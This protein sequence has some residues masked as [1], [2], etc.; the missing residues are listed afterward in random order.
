MKKLIVIFVIVGTLIICNNQDIK[1]QEV[2]RGV[3]RKENVPYRVPVP[4]PFMREADV[5]WSKLV[6]RNIDFREKTNHHLYYPTHPIGNRLSLVSLLINHIKPSDN[7]PNPLVVF[8]DEDFKV[9][10]KYDEVLM[11]LGAEEV[12]QEITDIDPITGREFTRTQTVTTEIQ[13]EEVLQLLVKEQW[14]FDRRHSMFRVRILA[15]CP[16]RVYYRLDD[17]GN[18]TDDL[19]RRQLFWVPFEDIRPILVRQEVHSRFNDVSNLSFD[20]VFLQRLFSGFIYQESNVFDN[21]P[22]AEYAIGRAALYE[23]QRIQEFLFNFEQDL[24][25]Y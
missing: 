14:F 12:T 13:P 2:T 11:R 16:V 10:L 25:E 1:S 24:W 19:L 8:D 20:D 18:E 22:I 9:P 4:M 5:T 6:W 23:S 3:Y 15:I 21:R 7:N 17:Q